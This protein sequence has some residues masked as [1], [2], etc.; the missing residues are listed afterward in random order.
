MKLRTRLLVTMGTVLMTFGAPAAHAVA[1]IQTVS[2]H[3]GDK[4]D[5]RSR[6]CADD[7]RWG[8][9]DGYSHQNAHDSDLCENTAEGSGEGEHDKGKMGY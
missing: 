5:Y 6:T 4:D 8:Y 1:G 9:G 2:D 7:H 3:H